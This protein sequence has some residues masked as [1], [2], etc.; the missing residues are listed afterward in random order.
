[1]TCLSERM[2]DEPSTRQLA[3]FVD[4]ICLDTLTLTNA[5]CL[6]ALQ[7][8]R[9]TCGRE[10]AVH[11]DRH[12]PG[13]VASQSARRRPHRL[14]VHLPVHFVHDVHPTEHPEATRVRA[15]KSG[16]QA[17]QQHVCAATA[18]TTQRDCVRHLFNVASVSAVVYLSQ[19]STRVQSSS[20]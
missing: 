15:V 20:A 19:T 8:F 4:A 5:L 3:R 6:I 11:S 13:T 14:F 9:R 1:M 2:V 12:G 18:L 17:E 16:K 7:Q 10:A